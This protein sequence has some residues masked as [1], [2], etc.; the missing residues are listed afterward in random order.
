[1][2]LNPGSPISVAPGEEIRFTV[3]RVKDTPCKSSW[4]MSGWENCGADQVIDDHTRQEVC[5]AA[6]TI[7]AKCDS[8]VAVDFTKDS[9]GTYDPVP[10]ELLF[11]SSPK[12]YP[13]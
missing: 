11:R 7:G 1:M 13:A 4:K 8:A 6:Q 5:T 12:C 10:G 2:Q 3:K 9:E